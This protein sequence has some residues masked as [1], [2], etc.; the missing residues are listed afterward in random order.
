MKQ[1]CEP[2]IGEVAR[3]VEMHTVEVSLIFGLLH[4]LL[5]DEDL[6]LSLCG[7]EDKL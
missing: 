5:G 3:S 1:L 2:T 7:C 4:E 6:F